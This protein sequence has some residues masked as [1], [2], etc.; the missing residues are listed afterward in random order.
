MRSVPIAKT[1]FILA[2][3]ALVWAYGYT[4]RARQW[5]P[6]DFIVQGW[7]QAQ[8]LNPFRP[9][10]YAHH[11]VH[12][13]AGVR[14]R[15][16]DRMQPGLTLIVSAWRESGRLLPGLRLLDRRGA[17][18][19]EWSIDPRQ[20]FSESPTPEIA[21]RDL[22]IHGAHL[23]ADGDVLLNLEYAATLRLDAC[24]RVVWKLAAGNH[25]SIAPADDGTFWIP[26]VTPEARRSTPASPHGVDG[27]QVPV[28]QD[29]ILRVD[30]H[31]VILDSINVLDVL[32]AN[33]LQ[34]QLVKRERLYT[35]DP[36]HL[37][38]I[39]PLPDSLADEY[40]GLEAGDLLVSLRNLD[41]IAILDPWSG[42]IKWHMTGNLI[43]QHDPDFIGDG[44]IGVFDN[45]DDDTERGGVLGGSRILAIQPATDST[46]VLFPTPRA[47]PFYTRHRGKWQRLANGNLLLTEESAGRVVEVTSDGQ[48]VWEWVVEPIGD[49]LIPAVTEATRLDLSREAVSGWACAPDTRNDESREQRRSGS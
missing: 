32:Y 12:E 31:G 13:R 7:H 37:N 42:Q 47:D 33:E 45:R 30:E 44:W 15:D 35:D 28:Y 6:H 2:S 14:V 26:G 10:A 9:P 34:W 8:G 39:E 29:L 20:V 19:H 23:L 11:A 22:D 3:A 36:T 16:D 18:V 40:P 24:S 17:T 25:H 48:T 49:D 1:A 43:K 21:V 4:T 38:D 41:L 27:I 5:V 46:R